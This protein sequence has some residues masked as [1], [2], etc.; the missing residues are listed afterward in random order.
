MYLFNPRTKRYIPA[1]V[2]SS[3]RNGETMYQVLFT[4]A[5]RNLYDDV[6]KVDKNKATIIMAMVS[7]WNTTVRISNLVFKFNE[8]A[9]VE[10]KHNKPLNLEGFT[11]SVG[12][13]YKI[14]SIY[15]VGTLEVK[16]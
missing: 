15:G 2:Y 12:T 16:R 7:Q 5:L 3:I 9:L 10:L 11:I 4:D 13:V 8:E 14:L 1:R 6:L